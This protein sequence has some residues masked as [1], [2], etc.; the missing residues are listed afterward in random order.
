MS[1]KSLR[2]GL[3]SMNLQSGFMEIPKRLSLEIYNTL[4]NEALNQDL[5]SK[6]YELTV[7]T[8]VIHDAKRC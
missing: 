2:D 3:K 8:C 6:H 1:I 7:M 4:L 5:Q